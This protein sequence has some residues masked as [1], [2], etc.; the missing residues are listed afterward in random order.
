MHP[1]PCPLTP[2]TLR[3]AWFLGWYT[4]SHLPLRGPTPYVPLVIRDRGPA[5]ADAWS[6]AWQ[7]GY[8]DC[9]RHPRDHPHQA[10]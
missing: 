9:K 8:E 5:H 1:N 3:S 2:R 7:A 4:R 6:L 10:A